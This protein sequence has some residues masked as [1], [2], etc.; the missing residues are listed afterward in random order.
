MELPRETGQTACNRALPN[1]GSV[2][3]LNGPAAWGD[4]GA[5]G[6]EPQC[7]GFG[8]QHGGYPTVDDAKRMFGDTLTIGCSLTLTVAM[9]L[10]GVVDEGVALG[11]DAVDGIVKYVY[12]RVF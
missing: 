2:V 5:A 9:P 10:S 3:D 4:N 8:L 7:E 1:E 11:V 6:A 12:H